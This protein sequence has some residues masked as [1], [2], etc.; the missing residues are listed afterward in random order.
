MGS[1]LIWQ[2]LAGG[3]DTGWTGDMV[4]LLILWDCTTGSVVAICGKSSKAY[5]KYDIGVTYLG[6]DYTH[7]V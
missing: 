7:G 5:T 2:W 6:Q 1:N 4:A 3:R